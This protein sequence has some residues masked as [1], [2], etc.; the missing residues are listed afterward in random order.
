[1]R[2]ISSNVAPMPGRS[3]MAGTCFPLTDRALR[4]CAQAAGADRDELEGF[5]KEDV[6]CLPAEDNTD[7]RGVNRDYLMPN[8]IY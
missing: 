7:L 6:G 8:R 2:L 3:S 1:M 5:L 4:P